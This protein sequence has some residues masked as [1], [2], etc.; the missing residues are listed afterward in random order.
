MHHLQN[1]AGIQFVNNDVKYPL[2]SFPF[3]FLLLPL[4]SASQNTSMPAKELT[5]LCLGDSYTIGESVHEAD[6]FPNQAVLLLHSSGIFLAKPHIIAA[7]GWT[8]DE[9]MNAI[10]RDNLLREYPS[11][12][13]AFD[14]VTLLIGVNNQYRSRDLESYRKEFSGLLDLAITYAGG[15]T[16]HVIVLSIPD[17]GVTAFA[18]GRDRKKISLEINQFNAVNKEESRKRKV[19]YIDITVYTRRHPEW[20]EADGLHPDSRQY[21]PWAQ[22]V[23]QV[24][25]QEIR[26]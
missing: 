15:K 11:E 12:R 7:T 2:I 20:V 6:R 4:S 18:E 16:N 9:L 19:H 21:E 14:F 24:I 25:M 3:L 22:E 8:T 17:W 13:A 1:D 23:K 10:Q 26:K 5:M